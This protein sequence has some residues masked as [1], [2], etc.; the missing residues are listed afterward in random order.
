MNIPEMPFRAPVNIRLPNG[1]DHTFHNVYDALDF[2]ENEWPLK[3]GERYDRAVQRCRAALK[4]IA[5]VEI[6]REAFIAA[7][8]EAGMPMVAVA[9]GRSS[10]TRALPLAVPA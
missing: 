7:C 8:L 1:L 2:L 10:S 5:P 3:R 4:R 6:A 9:T